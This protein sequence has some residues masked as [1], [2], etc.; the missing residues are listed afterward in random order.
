[1]IMI[2]KNMYALE[3]LQRLLLLVTEICTKLPYGQRVH[4]TKQAT[5]S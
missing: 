3:G 5:K 2:M 1:M 4:T